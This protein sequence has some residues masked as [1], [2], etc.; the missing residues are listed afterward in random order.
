[1]ADENQLN[2]GADPAASGDGAQSEGIQLGLQKVYVKDMS[3]ESPNTPDVFSEQWQPNVQV[4]M[5]NRTQKI[6]DDTFEVNLTVTVT[7]KLGDKTAFLAEVQQAGIFIIRNVTEE[8]LNA[9]TGSYCP[10]VL[11]PFA[12]QAVSDLVVQGGFPAVLLNP[13]NFDALYAQQIKQREESAGSDV[14]S[15]AEDDLTL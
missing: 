13:V 14:P 10:N 1:M 11:F 15:S 12:R 7:G 3:Y 6:A 9:M 8:Q 2:G 5:N 4:G